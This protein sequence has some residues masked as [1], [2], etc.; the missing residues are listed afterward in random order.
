MAAAA[1]FASLFASFPSQPVIVEPIDADRVP[2]EPAGDEF[3]RA[4]HR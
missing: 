2:L 4:S 3:G 1:V